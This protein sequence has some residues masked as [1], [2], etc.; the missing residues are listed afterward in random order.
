M[1]V[2]DEDTEIGNPAIRSHDALEPSGDLGSRLERRDDE[3]VGETE[4][5][6]DAKGDE[7]VLDVEAT[8]ER[9]GDVQPLP[10]CL[11]VDAR[12]VS[13][14][15]RFDEAHVAIGTRSDAVERASRIRAQLGHAL[16]SRRIRADYTGIGFA[17][18]KKARLGREV[19]LHGLMVIE[20]VLREVAEGR[21]GEVAP[22]D[23]LKVECV[24]RDLAC[25]HVDVG[26]DHARQQLLEIT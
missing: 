22:P 6:A 9:D 23:T 2:V 15:T 25:A 5:D 10:T 12:R 4:R 20:M 21:D 16:A 11:E 18:R 17:L 7:R 1:R 19:L 13:V 8:D 14:E 3:L 24:T 26:I